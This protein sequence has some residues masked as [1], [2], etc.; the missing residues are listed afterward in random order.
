VLA[1]SQYRQ[2]LGVWDPVF[3]YRPSLNYN[4][5]PTSNVLQAPNGKLV[6]RSFANNFGFSARSPWQGSRL[7]TTFDNARISTNNPFVGLNPYIQSSLSMIFTQPILRGR[8]IDN[9]RALILIRR[10]QIDI[11][12]ADYEIR[13]VDIVT[14]VQQAYWD[15]VAAREDI[16]VKKQ[17]VDLARDQYER[18]KRQIDAGTLAP[19][20][21]SA[22]EAELERRQDTYYTSI[23]F[24]TEVENQL[25]AFI[26]GGRDKEIWNDE[27]LPTEIRNVQPPAWDDVGGAVRAALDKRPELKQLRLRLESNEYNKALAQNLTLPG[28][29]L[30][31]GFTASGLAGTINNTPNPFSS[32]LSTDRIN[33]LSRLAGLPPI[34][35]TN[36]GGPP[37]AFL[38]GYGSTLSN[39]FGG[40]FTGWQAGIQFDWT[41]RNR[42]AKENVAQTLLTDRTLGLQR[43]RAEQLIETEVRNVLQQLNTAEQRIV[44]GAASVRA[45]KEKLDSEQ[46][47][48]ETGE[49]TN[50]LVLTRQNEF[51][52]SQRRS[53]I[54]RLDFNKAVARL[55]QALGQSL[56]SHR[57]TLK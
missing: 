26:S 45:A 8:T 7:E 46:R 56:V 44:S 48:F 9:D 41:L 40:G 51:A 33:D 37:A 43:A 6:D 57:I 52:D 21:L 15:L 25:K 19:V 23:G 4:V 30:T 14:R 42:A 16:E 1:R 17:S 36:F 34:P 31:G 2:V 39:L 32:T 53:L 54:A 24:L 49:S 55:E 13:V 3:G 35:V 18:S 22:A 38:G 10:K 5:T 47:L 27:L 11:S 50:F 28:L 20:E 12:E 29:S